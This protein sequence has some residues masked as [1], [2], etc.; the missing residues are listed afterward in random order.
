MERG[1]LMWVMDSGCGGV[2][3][4][5]WVCY[6]VLTDRVERGGMC[7]DV[8]VL[9][10][11][12]SLRKVIETDGQILHNSWSICTDPNAV[13]KYPFC[14]ITS[15]WIRL[16]VSKRADICIFRRSQPE[17]K[18]SALVVVLNPAC[19]WM[20]LVLQY[21]A[22]KAAVSIFVCVSFVCQNTMM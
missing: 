17:T 3:S 21:A 22:D 7:D 5:V 1:L 6:C 15:S 16:Y 9:R 19:L 10:L 20:L 18:R 4:L 2:S 13:S 12:L 14:H 11:F 8:A